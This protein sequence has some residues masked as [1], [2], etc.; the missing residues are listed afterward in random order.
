MRVLLNGNPCLSG[1]LCFKGRGHLSD[2][3]RLI[4]ILHFDGELLL[5]FLGLGILCLKGRGHLSD[6]YRL[7]FILHFDGEL[8]LHF[9]GLGI[10]GGRVDE[11]VV[12]VVVMVVVV[13]V[14]VVE[15]VV[16]VSKGNITLNQLPRNAKNYGVRPC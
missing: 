14:V 7:I 3:Y 15:E 2:V 12:V 4:F 8:L 6:V 16:K 11:V 5:H 13:V 10:H 1:I 9:L